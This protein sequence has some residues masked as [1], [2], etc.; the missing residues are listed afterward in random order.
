MN[1]ISASFEELRRQGREQQ[2][3]LA[4][5]CLPTIAMHTI[6]PLLTELKALDRARQKL[7]EPDS[8]AMRIAVLEF[9]LEGLHL[10][11]RLNKTSLDGSSV[12]GG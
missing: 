7:D 11:K 3:L 4:F 12:Y 6:P 10:G 9:V 2:A 8:E 5:G 1:E